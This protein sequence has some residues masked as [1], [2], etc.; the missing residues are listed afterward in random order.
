[1]SDPPDFDPCE[2]VWNH[3]LAMRR[4]I[5]LVSLLFIFSSYCTFFS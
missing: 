2:C 5:S 3:E 1:M 4:L